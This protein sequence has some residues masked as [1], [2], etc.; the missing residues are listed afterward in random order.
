[1]S[2]KGAPT[3]RKSIINARIIVITVT[4]ID[5]SPPIRVR[6]RVRV[7]VRSPLLAKLLAI[8]L[9]QVDHLQSG[10]GLGT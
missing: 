7:R 9:F 2:V 10:L 4:I 5:T 1:M 3:A 8:L 6:V